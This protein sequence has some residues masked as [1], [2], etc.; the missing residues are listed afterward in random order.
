M[1]LL[2]NGD[3]TFRNGVSLPA[4]FE[5]LVAGD[6]NGDGKQDLGVTYLGGVGILLGN[7][8]GPSSPFLLCEPGRLKTYWRQTLIRT[9]GLTLPQWARLL[10]ATL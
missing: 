4:Q 9:A 8:D 5:F 10:L 3:G 1:I 7:G 6:F 2:G